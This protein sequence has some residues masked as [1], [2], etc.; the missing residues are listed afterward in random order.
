MIELEELYAM[1]NEYKNFSCKP[2][3]SKVKAD[4][5]FDENLSVKWNRAEAERQNKQH[6]EEVK[7]L[8]TKKNQLFIDFKQAV[9]RYII[10][11]TCVNEK[12][13]DKIYNY[14]YNKYHAYGFEECLA[15][16]DE[17]LE[18]FV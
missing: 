3:T 14:L 7:D 5:V 1:A 8:N 11:E 2:K 15:N 18:L 12:K 16:L 17:L 4:F 6:E 10:Q 13:A 9:K